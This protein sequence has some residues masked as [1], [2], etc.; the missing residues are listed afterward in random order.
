M[1]SA[2]FPRFS[3][4]RTAASS[5]VR[6]TAALFLLALLLIPA[7]CVSRIAGR[8]AGGLSGAIADHPDPAT[9]R[10]GA[11]AYLLMV[12]AFLRD[13]PENENLL[14]SAAELYASYADVFV[15]DPD[16]RRT[17]TDRGLDYGLRA[18]RASESDIGDLRAMDFGVFEAALAKTGAD[19]VP[20]LYALGA[21]WAAWIQARKD[22]WNAIA[23]IARVEAVMN[24]GVALDETYRDG[25]GHL[26]LGVLATLVAPA[27]GGRPE[28]GREHFE[29]AIEL[30]GGKN[31]MAK[32][33]FARHY[34]R[35]VFDREIHDRL[36]KEVLEADP[37]VPGYAL[38]NRLAQERARELLAGSE[39]FF[40]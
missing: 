32:V 37:N 4:F 8:L 26:Y 33:L 24:R 12:D 38:S 1:I 22:D 35:T 3:P 20:A 31:L 7:G 36:L 2:D 21:A 23:D 18:I 5:G 40:E 34:A 25:G 28:E 13:D 19:D 10:D 30:S 11:P 17:L 16:R 15:D 27:L 6:R 14:R 9:V 39:E 29:R